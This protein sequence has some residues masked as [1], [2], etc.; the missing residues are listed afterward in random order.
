MVRA[1]MDPIIRDGWGRFPQSSLPPRRSRWW[2]SR[3][4]GEQ[5]DPP[6]LASGRSQ[7]DVVGSPVRGDID[8]ARR[9]GPARPTRVWRAD[10][11]RA[12][13][14]SGGDRHAPRARAAAFTAQARA[15]ERRRAAWVGRRP[16]ARAAA[17]GRQPRLVARPGVPESSLSVSP[18]RR[19][20]RVEMSA[21]NH[22]PKTIS[23]HP[24]P[25]DNSMIK[26]PAPT[27]AAASA[28]RPVRRAAT[29]LT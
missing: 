6:K 8:H 1:D 10:R 29:R 25:A 26:M 13:T 19:S 27:V 9:V 16:L 7:P 22:M 15:R 3:P 24:M 5:A 28:Y 23:A 14:A 4:T 17:C 18:A 20:P 11:E 21:A 2:S 12:I